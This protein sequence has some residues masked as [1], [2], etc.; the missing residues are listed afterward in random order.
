MKRVCNERSIQSRKPLDLLRSLKDVTDES[1]HHAATKEPTRG[2]V[3][4][5]EVLPHWW[6]LDV[7][8]T[9]LVGKAAH[10]LGLS[11]VPEIKCKHKYTG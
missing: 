5:S 4:F 9:S 7:K 6:Q 1:K 8:T 11:D 10:A 2:V 3:I